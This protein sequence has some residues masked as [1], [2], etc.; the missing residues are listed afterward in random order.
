[1]YAIKSIPLTGSI[2]TAILALAL[3]ILAGCAGGSP[4][5][6]TPDESA[7]NLT[8]DIL[9]D[10]VAGSRTLWGLWQGVVDTQAGTIEFVPLRQSALHINVT[11]VLNNTLGLSV[12]ID[13]GA[14]DPA[15]GLFA[16]DITL[17]HPFGTKPQLA[18][19]DV[20]GIMMNPGTLSI[21][22]LVF[23]GLD[24]TRLLNADGHS[25]WWNPSEF[26]GSGMLGYEP[27]DLGIGPAG[28]L[29]ATVNPYRYFCDQLLA[30]DDIEQIVDVPMDEPKGRGVFKA[31]QVNMR[32]YMIQFPLDPGPQIIFN[33]A[34][35]AS[36]DFPVPNP[37]GE[38]P[39]DFKIGANQPEVYY[40]RPEIGL[41][42]LAYE[43]GNT[44]NGAFTL[45]VAVHDWQGQAGGNIAN[46]VA[47]VMLYGPE[48][49]PDYV[50]ASFVSETGNTAW[51]SADLS[52]Y[53]SPSGSGEQQVIAAVESS[54]GL[55]YSTYAP[56]SPSDPVTAYRVFTVDVTEVECMPD[57]N[58]DFPEAVSIDW[59]DSVWDTV[60]RP[61]GSLVDYTDF[62]TFNIFPGKTAEGEINLYCYDPLIK[63][64][65]HDGAN[66]LIAE[67][68]VSGSKTTIDLTS[69][70]LGP[71]SYYIRILTENES[72]TTLYEL[73]LEGAEI[74]PPPPTV[75]DG[76]NG[77]VYPR[78]KHLSVY[79][80]VIDSFLPVTYSWNVTDKDGAPVITD[81]PGD[82]AGSFQITFADEAIAEGRCTISCTID[83]GT[84]PPV[85]ATPLTVYVNGLIF[86]ANLDDEITGDNVGWTT[87]GSTG[88]TAWTMST[89]SDDELLGLGRKFGAQNTDYAVDSSD[90][91][92]SPL[93]GMPDDVETAFLVVRH[94]FDLD[95]I[96]QDPSPGEEDWLGN[97]G[98]NIK[99]VDAA[100]LPTYTDY[101][102]P[103]LRGMPYWSVLS[104]GD[105]M[106]EDQPAFCG[107]SADPNLQ[108]DLTT[109]LVGIDYFGMDIYL[110]FAVTSGGV[111]GGN[112]GWLIDDVRIYVQDPDAENLG[113]VLD[114]LEGGALAPDPSDTVVWTASASDPDGERVYYTWEI[115]D[116][117]AS[118][119]RVEPVYYSVTDN[120]LILKPQDMMDGTTGYLGPYSTRYH[121][122]LN[123]T[124]GY[125]IPEVREDWCVA[126][127]IL[128]Q[129]EFD[130]S[131]ED[132]DPDNWLVEFS[133]GSDSSWEGPNTVDDTLGGDG[134]KFGAADTD[135]TYE[136]HSVLFS[137]EIFVP[138]GFS[139]VAFGFSHYFQFRESSPLYYDGGN[140][141]ILDG[142]TYM[143]DFAWDSD[144]VE[145]DGIG[146]VYEGVLS[147]GSLLAGQSAFSE[148]GYPA[149][150]RLSLHWM[151]PVWFDGSGTFRVAFAAATGPAG[152]VYRGWMINRVVIQGYE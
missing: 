51:Y 65:L 25:R 139:T 66:L 114:D 146:N 1:M 69:L 32:R 17:V 137:P 35:D 12:S 133:E 53:C 122:T 60:C 18:G 75:T 100:L 48:I 98:G 126:G 24:E 11:G 152:T 29:T 144:P 150:E 8:S 38:V 41:N 86:N 83:D 42:T 132:Y 105:T 99:I 110:G 89:V 23:S 6:P 9:T 63:I 141:H 46:E 108:V 112:R 140:A 77:T 74:E 143:D 142:E 107:Y 62:Y 149:F 37:P 129:A 97:D 111:D 45:S 115:F 13:Q 124:D 43:P 125:H 117:R 82:G 118:G 16:I 90:I 34:I 20:K 22:P 58:N 84:H 3:P 106:M 5:L 79:E 67:K 80:I 109:T 127:G 92:V 135:Y 10:P 64:S 57:T 21:P 4:T 131:A 61:G 7:Q 121:I 47:G 49:F 128:F 104:A 72:Q 94:S 40:I 73:S 136:D 44:G 123:A 14:S 52:E 30:Q 59:Y 81:D 39:D 36:W 101:A 31:G 15:A 56:G 33:Y 102:P 113:V 88:T 55:L 138:P 91:L 68:V 145:L 147:F 87:A 76:V 95:S 85:D 93:I 119:I 103:D 26:T 130:G 27:G 148:S 151:D 120:E 50:L 116:Y 134:Y 19:F 71:D 2:V 70:E 28:M 96:E 78:N 54:D